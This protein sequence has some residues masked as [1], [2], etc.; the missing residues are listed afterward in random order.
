M[1]V[2]VVAVIFFVGLLFWLIFIEE[3][4]PGKGWFAF[5]VQDVDIKVRII[6]FLLFIGGMFC[7]FIDK[8]S[9]ASILAGIAFCLL[10]LCR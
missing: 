5:S 6:S 7:V 2:D 3:G 8:R 9:F 4:F 10:V 1:I